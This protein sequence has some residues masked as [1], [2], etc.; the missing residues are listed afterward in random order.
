MKFVVLPRAAG[1]GVTSWFIVFTSTGCRYPRASD[2]AVNPLPCTV[3]GVPPSASTD[4]GDT[5][6]TTAAGWYVYSTLP[7]LYC[8][9][10]I[11]SSRRFAPTECTGVTHSS[12]LSS[13]YR[14]STAHDAF[15]NRH[16]S[17]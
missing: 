17:V 12:W 5:K 9:A 10:F 6:L 4:D 16:R 2:D 15:S 13:T 7:P 8:C 11:D 1:W 14:A 3:T